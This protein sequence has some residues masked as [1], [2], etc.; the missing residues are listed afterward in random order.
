MVEKKVTTR[1]SMQGWTL[2]EWAFRNKDNFKAA[3]ILLAGY[4]YIAGFTWSS[5]F[6]ALAAVGGKIII[7]T[8]DYW[9]KEE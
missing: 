5:F 1:F 4:N 8:I 7:D 6:V 2:K 3:I 9:L